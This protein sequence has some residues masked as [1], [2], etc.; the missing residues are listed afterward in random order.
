ML[1]FI[2][3]TIIYQVNFFFFFKKRKLLNINFYY[4]TAINK[5][6]IMLGIFNWFGYKC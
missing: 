3:T 6:M 1:I 2:I 4:M 5:N